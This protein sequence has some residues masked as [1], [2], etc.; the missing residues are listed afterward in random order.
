MKLTEGAWLFD[1]ATQGIFALLGAYPTF[2][3]GGCVRNTLLGVPVKDIDFATEARPTEV[4]ALAEAAGMHAI[5]TGIEHG[6]VTVVLDEVPFEITTFRHDVETD[7]RRA[8]IAFA[9]EV[10]EDARR[11]DFT[12]NAIYADAEGNILDPVG[13]LADIAA[14]RI[15]FIEDAERRIR[16]DYLRSLRFFRFSAWY[17]DPSEGMDPEAL[18]AIARNL[19]GLETLSRER[20]GAELIRLLSAPDP[21]PAVAAMRSTG[22]LNTILPGSDDRALA[23]LVA[24][25]Q[26]MGVDPSPARRLAALGGDHESLRLSRALSSQVNLIRVGMGEQP[27][28]LGY[29]HGFVAGRDSLLVAGAFAGQAVSEA[30]MAEVRRGSDATFPVKA[31]DLMPKWQGRELGEALRRLEDAWIESG[32]TLTRE[33]LLAMG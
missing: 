2:A 27:G 16:E 8:V 15:R 18:D 1:P 14:R 7:G 29:R 22:V 11:R 30:A 9:D 10:D 13:G 21:A 31:A 25:E 5:P 24:L 6:T 12:I 3:V 28:A 33:A 4:V 20:V 19:P 32:F 26:S 23:P 17:G